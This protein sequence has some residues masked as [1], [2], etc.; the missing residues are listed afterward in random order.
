MQWKNT[1]AGYGSITIILHWLSVL[2]ILITYAM[3]D[4]KFLAARGSDL[5]KHMP[6]WHYAAGLSVFALAWARLLVRQFGK[7]PISEPAP[8]RWITL[9][10]GAIKFALYA[11]LICLPVLGWLTVNAQGS[12]V[13]YFGFSLPIL[14]GANIELANTLQDLHENIARSEE[15]RVGKECRSR[16]SP[17]H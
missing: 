6:L 4:L 15:R 10:A 3:M 7:S 14:I 16:W 11:M 9:L 2:L 17:Y 13:D 5:R 12:T 8:E 1:T